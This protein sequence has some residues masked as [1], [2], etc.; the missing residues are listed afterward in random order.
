MSSH[1][2]KTRLTVDEKLIELGLDPKE[3]ETKLK[4]YYD[5]FLPDHGKDE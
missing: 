3:I 2:S 1:A 5:R 4:A